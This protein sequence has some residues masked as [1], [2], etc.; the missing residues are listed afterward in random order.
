M[1]QGGRGRAPLLLSPLSLYLV[2]GFVAHDDKHGPGAG[3]DPVFDEG[4]DLGGGEGD[5]SA[6][7]VTRGIGRRPMLLP[8]P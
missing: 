2:A 4:A 7:A 6:A 5:A 8:A 3:G 1:N